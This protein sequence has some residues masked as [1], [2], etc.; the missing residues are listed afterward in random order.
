MA[1][2]VMVDQ[3]RLP[4]RKN[5]D[6]HDGAHQCITGPSL[7]SFSCKISLENLLWGKKGNL[8]SF[9]STTPLTFSQWKF[10]LSLSLIIVW[11]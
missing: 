9:L 2:N 7:M 10:S 5:N 8:P 4:F 3:T 6:T 1:I 11:R